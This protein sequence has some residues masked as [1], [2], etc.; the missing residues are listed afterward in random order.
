[1]TD[2]DSPGVGPPSPKTFVVLSQGPLEPQDGIVGE[3]SPSFVR[4]RWTKLSHPL[5]VF[6]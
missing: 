1:M 6:L 5:N 2:G 3:E 4:I